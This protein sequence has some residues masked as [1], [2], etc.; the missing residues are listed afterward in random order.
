MAAMQPEPWL[1]ALI[2]NNN[3]E[4]LFPITQLSFSCTSV[5][6]ITVSKLYFILCFSIQC[7]YYHVIC[8]YM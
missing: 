3:Y 8:T 6:T 5:G 1:Q 7:E 4:L 2:T